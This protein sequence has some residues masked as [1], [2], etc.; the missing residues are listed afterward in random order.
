MQKLTHST[1]IEIWLIL[2]TQKYKMYLEQ[3]L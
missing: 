3:V 1:D 2:N